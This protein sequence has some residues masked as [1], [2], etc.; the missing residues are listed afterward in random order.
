MDKSQYTQNEI[1]LKNLV[2]KIEFSYIS[3]VTNPEK[4]L[5]KESLIGDVK[6]FFSD[7]VNN[8]DEFEEANFTDL[9]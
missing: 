2:E 7:V 9:D 6:N 5:S 8:I 3:F 1:E 4:E